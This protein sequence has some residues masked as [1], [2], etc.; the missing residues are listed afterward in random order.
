[1]P[2]K[3]RHKLDWFLLRECNEQ[4]KYVPVI[5]QYSTRISGGVYT[6]L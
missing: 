4:E 6:T 3:N 5:M 2:C 1:M